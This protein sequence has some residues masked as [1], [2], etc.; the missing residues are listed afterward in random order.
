MKVSVLFFANFREILD[1]SM[2]EMD[3]EEGCSVQELCSSLSAIG[4]QW[5]QLFGEN[6]P[7]VKV[8]VNQEMATLDSKL[9]HGDEIA[10]FPPVTGG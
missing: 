10:F 7:S 8:S 9:C 3:L 1:C 2:L 6:T 5:S 4:Q